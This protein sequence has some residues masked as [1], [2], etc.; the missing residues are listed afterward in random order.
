MCFLGKVN[1]A[2]KKTA[3]VILA[4][5]K[6]SWNRSVSSII[7]ETESNYRNQICSVL[8][9]LTDQFIFLMIELKEK[10]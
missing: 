4:Y 5:E 1:F 2:L 9:F 6:L 8:I 10:P 7:T 3:S